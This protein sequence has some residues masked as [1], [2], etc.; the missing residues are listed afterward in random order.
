MRLRIGLATKNGSLK[1]PIQY[2][3]LLYSL[4]PTEPFGQVF[5]QLSLK[6]RI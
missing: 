1:P 5:E 3:D 6:R 2:N 4:K